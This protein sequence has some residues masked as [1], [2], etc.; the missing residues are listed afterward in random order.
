MEQHIIETDKAP[1]AIGAYSQAVVYGNFLFVS[2]NLGLDPVDGN[3]VSG[4]ENQTKQSLENI[5]KILQKADSCTANIVKVTIYLTNMED[6]TKVNTIYANF[7][8]N[9]KPPARSCVG[10]KELP[11]GGLV[12][13]EVIAHVNGA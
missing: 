8:N 13:I 12:E 1:A 7:F 10:V 4:I 11:K 9:G 5:K 6:F 2:G 3:L